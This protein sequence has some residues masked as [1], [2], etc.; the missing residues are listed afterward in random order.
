MKARKVLGA[1]TMLLSLGAL[2]VTGVVAGASAADEV[3][4][5]DDTDA[6]ASATVDTK[7][8]CTWFVAGVAGGVVLD[9]AEDET[10]LEYDG[11]TL[12][13]DTS[14]NPLSDVEMYVSGNLGTGS[15][16]LHSACTFYGENEGIAFQAALGTGGFTA[17]VGETPD[18]AMNFDMGDDLNGNADG[19]DPVTF[20]YNAE[21]SAC[22][23]GST[24]AS[25]EWAA[26]ADIE[27]TNIAGVSAVDVTLLTKSNTVSRQSDTAGQNSACS[28]TQAVSVSVPADLTPGTPGSNYTF[29]GP[30]LT[31]GFNLDS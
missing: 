13:L 1:C 17:S 15:K 31:F 23:S 30:T 19:A 24:G 14:D 2:A 6:A 10:V 11:S 16:E 12:D 8:L 20:I 5:D 26:A 3:D 18:P 4:P 29:T 9:I 25:D 7:E 21:K 28:V 27:A 22:R